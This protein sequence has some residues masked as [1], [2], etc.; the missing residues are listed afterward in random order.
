MTPGGAA[1]VGLTAAHHPHTN[2]FNRRPSHPSLIGI[3]PD[4]SEYSSS[5]QYSH[6]HIDSPDYHNPTRYAP[7]N[8]PSSPIDR[9]PAATGRGGG[10][11][12]EIPPHVLNR[13]P[14][15]APKENISLPPIKQ[16]DDGDRDS[17][18]PYA[19][20]PISALEDLRGVDTQDSAAVLRRLRLDDD[21]PTPSSIPSQ[22]QLWARRH[23]VSAHPH[24]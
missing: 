1:N 2:H 13:S 10:L 21:Y 12:L 6:R 4:P 22:D 24:S 3:S 16:P 11:S 15:S 18:S 23:S 5:P 8:S 9:K 19:L 17:G 20:P 7:Y 14:S